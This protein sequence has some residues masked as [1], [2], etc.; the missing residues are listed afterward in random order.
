MSGTFEHTAHSVHLI[1]PTKQNQ[2]SLNVMLLHL[3]NTVGEVCHNLIPARL[4][5]HNIS[6]SIIK[7]IMSIF[8]DFASTNVTDSFTTPFLCFIKGVIQSNCLSPLVFNLLFLSF[9]KNSSPTWLF[10]DKFNMFKTLFSIYKQCHSS[11]WSIIPNPN[12][13]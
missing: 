8:E 9:H 7:A 6:D 12:S 3:R 2:R 4:V 10:V 1:C 5:H 13:V 11:Y